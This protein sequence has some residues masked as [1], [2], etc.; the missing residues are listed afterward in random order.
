MRAPGRIVATAV[1]A[2]VVIALLCGAWFWY[3]LYRDRSKPAATTQVV[4]PRGATFGD[5][6]AQ[7][8]DNGVIGNALSFRILARARHEDEAV[9]AG[10]YRFPPNQTAAEVLQALLTGGAQTAA[11]VSI[12]EGF[13]AIQIA[14]RLHEAGVGQAAA[15]SQYFLS[16]AITVDG[17]RTKNLEGYLFPSTYLVPLDATP[18]QI[19][20]QLTD[21]FFKQLPPDAPQ[22]AKALGISVPQGVVV[23]S[24]VEREAKVDADRPMIAGVIFNRLKQKMPLQVDATIEYALPSHKADLSLARFEDRLAVQYVQGTPV[25]RRRPSPIPAAP[26]WKRR[27]IRRRRRCCTTFTAETA[28]TFSPRLLPNIRPTSRVACTNHSNKELPHVV[29]QR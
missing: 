13:T 14:E 18:V 6:A 16:T 17:S 3:G 8:A 19:E 25:C 2:V 28:V 4:I 26:R 15:L 12:P 7:L 21:E 22:R 27:F 5:I 9:H 11:W 10:A 1:A 20:K 23:A 24:L 29:Q